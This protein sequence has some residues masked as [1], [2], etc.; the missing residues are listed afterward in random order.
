MAIVLQD[1]FGRQYSLK[2]K[3]TIGSDSSNR[4]VL[5]DSTSSP[6]H[7]EISLKKGG[8]LIKDN[9]S[10]N[11]VFINSNRITDVETAVPGDTISVGKV[12]FSVIDLDSVEESPV[13]VVEPSPA[14]P[15]EAPI[16]V[17]SPG[18]VEMEE[19]PSEPVT[20]QPPV[21]AL[22]VVPV[23]SAEPPEP[24]T[25][26]ISESVPESTPTLEIPSA[27]IPDAVPVIR[28]PL[29]A[30]IS[31]SNK[32]ILAVISAVILLGVI[33]GVMIVLSD[34]GIKDAISGMTSSAAN[35][36]G[37]AELNLK[38]P[39]LN[40]VFTTSFIQKQEDIYQG[41]AG[42]GTGMTVKIVQQNMEQSMPAWSN[43][44][45]YQVSI[46]DTVKKSSEFSILNGQVYKN[47]GKTCSVFADTGADGHKPS[48]W[49]KSFL[50]SYAA[51]KARKVESGVNINGVLADKYELT[52]ENSPFADSL[53][54]M[55]TGVL[56][57]AQKGGYLVRLSIT[58]TWQAD[59]WQGTATYGFAAKRPVIVTNT[60]DF[61]Y[62]PSGKLNV[63][64]PG[65]CAGKLKPVN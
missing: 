47:T 4:I 64:V 57:R 26:S 48:N 52:M 12:P 41:V 5:L 32:W 44:T 46:N 7:A 43:H 9:D 11:G 29:L 37:P 34:S 45:L 59:K 23:L 25:H 61:T 30:G 42:D 60:V 36:E 1:S 58:E 38:D 51:G 63:I 56:Y 62:Y 49:P 28:R 54:D 53:T 10:D 19:L 33:A 27:E 55:Q 14:P 35:G 65:V 22:P 21:S 6:F 15:V 17:K 8:V 13:V 18:Y 2:K 31:L 39:S 3:L 50:K 16:T 40:T 20:V 24:I